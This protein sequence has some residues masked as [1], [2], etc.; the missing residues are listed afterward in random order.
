MDDFLLMKARGLPLAK[1]FLSSF[2]ASCMAAPQIMLPVGE[3]KALY[4]W[5]RVS[6]MFF[7]L[8]FMDIL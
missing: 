3:V 4:C 8:I 7:Y 1:L 5:K 2:Q 6:S